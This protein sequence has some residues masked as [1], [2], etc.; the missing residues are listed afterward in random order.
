[1]ATKELIDRLN[2]QLNREV[3][4]ILRYMLQAAQSGGRGMSLS[5]ICI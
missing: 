5:G 4:T 2:R 3:A 1:M